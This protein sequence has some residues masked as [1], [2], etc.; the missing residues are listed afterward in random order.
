MRILRYLPGAL[1]I[2]CVLLIPPLVGHNI[3]YSGLAM[4]A[5]TWALANLGLTIILGYTGQISLGQAAFF[6]IGAYG[7][8]VVATKTQSMWLGLL[9]AIALSAVAGFIIG[10][11]TLKMAG[12]YLAMVTIGFQ[13]LISLVFN[14]W[15][16]LT[17]GPDGISGIPRPHIF[18]ISLMQNVPFLYF[19][20]I[21]L[22]LVAAGVNALR[23]YTWGR[24]LRGIRENELAANVMGV[25][26]F[27]AKIVAFTV[28]A[29]I[30]GFAGGVFATG[31]MYISPGLF[32]FNQSVSFL[33]MTVVGGAG[34]AVGT[35]FGTVVLTLLPEV[36]R[37]MQHIY[38][39]VYAIIVLLVVLGMPGGIW[40]VVEK[41]WA[42]LVPPK[43]PK[44][45]LQDIRFGVPTESGEALLKLNGISKSFGGL[46]AVDTVDL[47]LKSQE[48]HALVGPNGSG[49]TTV[50]NLVTGVYPLSGGTIELEGKSLTGLPSYR[51]TEN[52][53]AR[54]FQN[55]R[56]CKELTVLDNVMLGLH[57]HRK[58]TFLGNMFSSPASRRER[59]EFEE[60]AWKAIIYVGLADRAFEL[61]ENLPHGQQKL[62]ELARALVA[63][64]K[65]L[66]LDEPAAG[67]NDTETANLIQLLQRLKSQHV[68][69]LLI[70]HDMALVTK[71]ADKLTVL[72]FGQR[73]AVGPVQEV[74]AEPVVLEAFLGRDKE[75][76]QVVEA[77]G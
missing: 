15:I 59:R 24:A 72:S 62:V 57:R 76:D 71:V 54:T 3:Y 51:V 66:L 60:K 48:A 49:K 6:G 33:A 16:T 23:K 46:K 77:G 10:L 36:L 17:G 42:R 43:R 21:L 28:G 1:A 41:W 5:A 30:T 45:D 7:A 44:L 69:I 65:V 47:T 53:I 73:I 61:A 35:I 12:H 37:F 29:T 70:E 13:T 55:I 75:E 19:V 38:L 50:L 68:T 9:V 8:A 56:L 11:S 63:E 25:N 34:S 39:V 20:F 31:A 4:E 27:R 74:L 18:G 52:G 22:F 32:D 58:S 14:N 2:L 64:P 67:L 40:S 26:A